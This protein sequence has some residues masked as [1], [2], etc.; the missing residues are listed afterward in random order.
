MARPGVAVRASYA[1]SPVGIQGL[2]E[3]DVRG[4]VARDDGLRA[5]DGDDGPGLRGLV[6][7]FLEPAVVGRLARQ[8]LEAAL[9]VDRGAAPFR[10]GAV[11]SG[12]GLERHAIKS[13]REKRARHGFEV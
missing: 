7:G 13:T 5:L 10:C 12:R 1:A 2:V 4:V 9:Q 11:V 3:S 8:L 6:G